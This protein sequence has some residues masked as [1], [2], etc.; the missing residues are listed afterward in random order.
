[1]DMQTPVA[2]DATYYENLMARRG[3][4]HSDQEL[5]GG[6]SQD[7][8]VKL[9]S[10]DPALFRID[11]MEVIIKMGNINPLTGTAG[12]IRVNCRVANS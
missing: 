1:M 9:Y 3:L 5:F 6:G 8:L 7:V 4:F 10:K 11:F 2:F 12:E